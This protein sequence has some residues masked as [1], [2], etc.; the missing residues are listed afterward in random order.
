MTADRNLIFGLL[1]LQMDFVSGEQLLDAM[2]AWMLQK[3]T[4]LGEILCRQGALVE[5]ERQV[6]ELALEKHVR[7]HGNPQASLVA[8]KVEP[9]VR[10]D[11]DRLGD[12]EVQASVGAL[13]P[14][15]AETAALAT[16]NGAAAPSVSDLATVASTATPHSGA[17]YHRLRQ[18]AKGGLGEVFVALDQELN[19]EVALKEIQEQFADRP[20]ARA[21][22]L[23]EAEVTASLEHS[24]VV[25]VY[26]LGAYPNGRP[27][28]AMRFIR[29]ES[30]QDAIRRFHQADDN[31][32]R[33]PGERSLA[34]RELL[35]RFV[36]VCNAVAY[37]HSR[38]VLN[39]DLKPANAMLGEYGETLVVD[40]GL[41]KL[42]DQP[43]SE[44]PVAEQPV[45]VSS[46]SATALGQVVG[47]Y[48]F[49]PPEQAEGRLD[50]LGPR[51]DVFALGATLYSLLT[52]EAPSSG[53]DALTQA[54]RGEVV[55]A[56]Q[57]KRS[58][59]AAL[60]AVCAKAMAKNPEDRYPTAR[61]L[62]EEVQRWLGGEPVTAWP[63]PLAV[64]TGRWV[65]KHRVLATS[66]AVGLVVALAVLK[67]TS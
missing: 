14:T 54:R 65:R 25:P 50:Q 42:L 57:R 59:P 60:E 12:P 52:G 16:H 48:A 24:G 2:A 37:A 10:Q 41:A 62:A 4:P 17:R 19:R 36:A 39:R 5:D 28:Y 58:V 23:R 20:D 7:R 21:R 18:H 29:G 40:W 53:P 31:P 6:L 13:A 22:F 44:A 34:L 63:E 3:Q 66:V 56:R 55:P 51:S 15:P 26:G 27:Y 9:D 46:D 61:A 1:A 33:D 32:A 30:L 64:K 47:T 49:M 38:G 43:N 35:G 45:R 67:N 8:L 11:L